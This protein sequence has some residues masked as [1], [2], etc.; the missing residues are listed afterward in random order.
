MNPND[1]AEMM[2]RQHFVTNLTIP[3]RLSNIADLELKPKR[4][5][6][7]VLPPHSISAGHGFTLIELLVVI[8]IIAILAG[9][10]L[11]TLS[12]A[13][14]RAQM[15]KCLSNLHQIGIGM[16]LYLGDN[17]DTFP[18]GATAQF[19]PSASPDYNIGACLGGNDPL[20][21]FKNGIPPATNRLLNS[22]V[23][24]REAWHCPADGG[25]GPDIHPTTFGTLGCSYRFN[26]L[27]DL[28]YYSNSGVAEDPMYNLAMKTESWAPEPS[29]FIMMQEMGLYPWW[30]A[31]SPFNITSWHFAS[32]PGKVFSSQTLKNDPDKLISG[33]LFVDGHVQ[34]IDF[35]PIIK[36]NPMRAF[37]PGKDYMWYKPAK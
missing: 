32:N 22:Y 25:F 14:Q 30:N 16:K 17:N 15:I 2:F 18:P 23:P 6:H 20:P 13:K 12:K 3:N 5:R 4:R 10:L 1:A 31:N 19:D 27:L 29:R 11:P 28:D 9:M 26:W 33:V 8:A 24:A 37:E 35:S 34:Q 21:A 7:S 36:A